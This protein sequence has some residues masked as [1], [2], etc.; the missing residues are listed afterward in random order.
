VEQAVE[1]AVRLLPLA[2][3]A[4]EAVVAVRVLSPV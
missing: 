1:V 2:L 4:V 3:S